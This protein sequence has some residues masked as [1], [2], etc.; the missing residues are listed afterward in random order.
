ML[1]ERHRT[2]ADTLGESG[3]RHTG[4]YQA[5]GQYHQ[6]RSYNRCHGFSHN[7]SI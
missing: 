4:G 6:N 3:T 7:P 1:I 5:D 2:V